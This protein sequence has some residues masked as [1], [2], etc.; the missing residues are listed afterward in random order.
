MD[1]R[2]V[3][4]EMVCVTFRCVHEPVCHEGK[5]SARVCRRYNISG[6]FAVD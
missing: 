3:G 5:R 6:G 2:M 4:T 1:L